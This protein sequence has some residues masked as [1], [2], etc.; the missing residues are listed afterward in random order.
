MVIYCVLATLADASTRVIAHHFAAPQ[1]FFFSGAIGM[2]LSYVFNGRARNRKSLRPKAPWLLALRSGLFVISGVMYFH[3]FGTLVF[4]EVFAFIALVPIFAA[5]LSG[6][7]LA[8]PVRL[9]SW[10]AL[11]AGVGGMLVMHP[12]GFGSV[13]LGHVSALLGA[14]AGAAAM[15]LARLISRYDD[16]A[17]LQVFYPNMAMCAVMMVAL[18]FV[19]APMTPGFAALIAAYGVLIFAARLV[20]VMALARMPAYVVTPLI[21]MQFVFMLIFGIAVFGEIPTAGVV[22]GAVVIISAGVTL[23]LEQVWRQRAVAP[24]RSSLVPAE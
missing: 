17:M 2:A 14:L 16:N 15:V 4:V 3:A 10:C 22:L 11:V 19:F 6:P 13:T 20:L 21:N 18:P 12:Q 1:L 23:V 5:F 24:R 9:F 8:E 7:V